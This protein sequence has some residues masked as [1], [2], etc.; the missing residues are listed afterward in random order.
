[1]TSA[2][3]DQFIRSLEAAARRE[4]LSEWDLRLK[5]SSAEF[6]SGY[7]KKMVWTRSEV[8]EIFRGERDRLPESEELDEILCAL[9]QAWPTTTRP[10]RRPFD[11]LYVA[12]ISEEPSDYD[13]QVSSDEIV[14]RA[15]SKIAELGESPADVTVMSATYN[16]VRKDIIDDVCPFLRLW[17]IKQTS[18]H[19]RLVTIAVFPS[20]GPPNRVSTVG[21]LSSHFRQTDWRLLELEADLL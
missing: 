18:I 20:A 13:L 3:F 5:G 16:F 2:R 12:R 14:D 15:R 7:H 10:T 1:M 17:A 19:R 9:E 4:G 8:L 6:F 21:P 11:A